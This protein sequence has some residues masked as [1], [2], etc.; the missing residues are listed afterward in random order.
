M[1][2]RRYYVITTDG[3]AGPFTQEELRDALDQGVIGPRQ[4]VRTSLGTMLGTVASQLPSAS[5]A[6]PSGMDSGQRRVRQFNKF[7]LLVVFITLLLAALIAVSLR[8]AAAAAPSAPTV[9]GVHQDNLPAAEH[10]APPAPPVAATPS[11]P[12]ASAPAVQPAPAPP[13]LPP[14]AAFVPAPARSLHRDLVVWDGAELGGG[15]RAPG[16]PTLVPTRDANE[17]RHGHAVVHCHGEGSNFANFGWNWI[18][19]VPADGGTDVAAMGSLV[20][21]IRVVGE[22]AVESLRVALHAS[23]SKAAGNEV[24]VVRLSPNVRD[25]AWHE[26]TVPMASLVEGTAFNAH[27]AWEIEILTWSHGQ[28]AV[29]IYLDEIGFA[30]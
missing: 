30:R 2:P 12:V 6:R 20:F 26:V 4:Q 10:A 14:P 21:A 5:Q 13:A 29:D 28:H 7:S 18:G 8:P 11:G 25:G 1:D 9:G 17:R 3:E 24:D 15:W 22:P 16:P 27:K 23:T 19:W